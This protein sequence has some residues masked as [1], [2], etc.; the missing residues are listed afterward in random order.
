MI[1]QTSLKLESSIINSMLI[2]SNDHL[3]KS[4]DE[5]DNLIGKSDLYSILTVQLVV[6]HY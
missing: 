4:T 5:Y 3:N 1:V 6:S 2:F